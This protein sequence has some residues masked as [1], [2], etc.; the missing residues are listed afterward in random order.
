MVKSRI[1]KNHVL[2]VVT[3]VALVVAVIVV[4]VDH[5]LEKQ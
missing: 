3:V 1:E 2:L 4:L 5:L